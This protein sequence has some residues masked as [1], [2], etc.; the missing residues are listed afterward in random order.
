[1][2]NVSGLNKF[3]FL[4]NF[5]DIL[6]QLKRNNK[7]QFGSKTQRK[8]PGND[9]LPNHGEAKD[10]FDGTSDVIFKHLQLIRCNC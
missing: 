6:A 1:M 8:K 5:H 4:R 10:Q 9:E 7:V 2:L 3:Y